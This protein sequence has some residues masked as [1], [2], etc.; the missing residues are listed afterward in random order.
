MCVLLAPSFAEDMR[1]W[2]LQRNGSY[3]PAIAHVVRFKVR[4]GSA[5]LATTFLDQLVE[6]STGWTD[7]LYDSESK[8]YI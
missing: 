2:L 8:S 6:S 4:G 3:R 5:G 7:P 1:A